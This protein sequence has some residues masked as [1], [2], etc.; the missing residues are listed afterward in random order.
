MSA[1]IRGFGGGLGSDCGSPSGLTGRRR[2]LQVQLITHFGDGDESVEILSLVARK[3][4]G[5]DADHI[6]VAVE[7]GAAAVEQG[8]AAIARCYRHVS[9][10]HPL[11]LGLHLLYSADVTAGDR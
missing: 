7:Q 5:A 3:R 4:Q 6:A 8:A 11:I 1:A 10:Y 2:D 9:L